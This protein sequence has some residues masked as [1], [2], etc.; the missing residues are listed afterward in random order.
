MW[1]KVASRLVV[2]LTAGVMQTC[3]QRRLAQV[4]LGNPA[5]ITRN[6]PAPLP[7]LQ[8]SVKA[9]VEALPS[10]CVPFSSAPCSSVRTHKGLARATR[11]VADQLCG[12]GCPV[13]GG[14]VWAPPRLG[15]VCGGKV[16]LWD[17]SSRFVGKRG[18][19]ACLCACLPVS[20]CLLLLQYNSNG[21]ISVTFKL[22]IAKILS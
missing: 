12:G 8:P 11:A 20:A 9:R 18:L 17:L 6:P 5:E 15:L 22:Q 19:C 16:A 4:V 13:R 2:V 7:L 14:G 1:V 21:I 3:G 10:C